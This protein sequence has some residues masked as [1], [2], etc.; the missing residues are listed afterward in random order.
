V[1]LDKPIFVGFAILEVSKLPM[2]EFHYDYI[3]KTYGDRAKLLF[4]DTDSLTYHNETENLYADMQL[5]LKKLFD[6]SNF[7]PSQFLY[8]ENSKK[9]VG[10][11]RWKPG[12][13]PQ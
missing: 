1:L 10:S 7:D 13:W 11:L 2:Y 8:S 3:K 5:E 9:V 4:T 12:L 6:T